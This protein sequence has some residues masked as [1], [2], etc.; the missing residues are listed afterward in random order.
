MGRWVGDSDDATRKSTYRDGPEGRGR[1][2]EETR[3]RWAAMG[4]LWLVAVRPRIREERGFFM[5][6][7]PQESD[8]DHKPSQEII[9][10]V[11]VRSG[12]RPHVRMGVR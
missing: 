1:R 7:V 6:T 12:V 4:I 10:A 5:T 2:G 3:G 8:E 11:T 9:K